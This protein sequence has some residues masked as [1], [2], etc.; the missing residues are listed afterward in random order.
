MCWKKWVWL[1]ARHSVRAPDCAQTLQ[2]AAPA[3]AGAA[4]MARRST[5]RPAAMAAAT[6]ATPRRSHST[7]ATPTLPLHTP[8]SASRSCWAPGNSLVL[9]LSEPHWWCWGPFCRLDMCCVEVLMCR[10]LVW[11]PD[12]HRSLLQQYAQPQAAYGGYPGYGAAADPY[13]QQAAGGYGGGYGGAAAAGGGGSS[14]WQVK[15]CELY[16]SH[17]AELLT[18]LRIHS[19]SHVIKF[20]Q[21]SAFDTQ[22]VRRY[23]AG[24]SAACARSTVS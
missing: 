8:R 3:T 18:G 9:F 24:V 19:I 23:A 4:A 21:C 2:V 11:S 17:P 13:G 7:V 12:R 6:G 22:P 15:I 10:D 1:H 5:R 20:R 16:P 14:Q